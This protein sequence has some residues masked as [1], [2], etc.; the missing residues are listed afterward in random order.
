MK[1]RKKRL[2]ILLFDYDGTII[3]SVNL[4]YKIFKNIAKEYGLASP[5]SIKHFVEFY[6]INFYE[7]LLTRGLLKIHLSKFINEF[8]QPFL[9]YEKKM[10]IFPYMKETIKKLS[11]KAKIFIITSN[12]SDVIESSIKAH[13]IEHVSAVIGADNGIGKV[14]AIKLIKKRFPKA[15]IYY[16]G[17][18]SGD[19]IEA[20]KAG[21]KTIGVTWGYHS[22][23]KL[24]ETDPDF[25]VSAPKDLLKIID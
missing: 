21:V 14:N 2:I 8:R 3:D 13:K 25:I 24:K 1:N 20:K 15:I 4:A 23:L 7:S 11:K 17:D 22:R 10:K 16:I 12:L 18:T 9:D 19:M 5:K 6:N